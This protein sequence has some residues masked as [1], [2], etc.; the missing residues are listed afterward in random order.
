MWSL[1]TLN[2]LVKYF[3]KSKFKDMVLSKINL[4]AQ[5]AVLDPIEQRNNQDFCFEEQ[6]RIEKGFYRSTLFNR[7]H[8]LIKLSILQGEEE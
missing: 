5:L 7:N 6:T 3:I 1:F 2:S 4:F 8:I